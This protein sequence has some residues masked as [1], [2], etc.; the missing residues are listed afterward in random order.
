VPG[1]VSKHTAPRPRRKPFA[2]QSSLSHPS[3]APLM[4]A[5]S[6][7][8]LS[9]QRSSSRGFQALPVTWNNDAARR[10]RTVR[11]PLVVTAPGFQAAR[12]RPSPH[13][14]HQGWHR[15]SPTGSRRGT[16]HPRPRPEDDEASLTSILLAHTSPACTITMN[17][18]FEPSKRAWQRVQLPGPYSVATNQMRRLSACGARAGGAVRSATGASAWHADVRST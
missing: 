17:L 4:P 3:S 14:S 12:Q 11:R 10:D 18:L 2:L 1:P 15:L 9:N 7:A 6:P 16:S 8:I 13:P 5:G